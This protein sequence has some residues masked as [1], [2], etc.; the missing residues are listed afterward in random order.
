MT[1]IDFE[2]RVERPKQR[3]DTDEGRPECRGRRARYAQRQEASGARGDMGHE[4][5][6]GHD[7]RDMVARGGSATE[8]RPDM[9]QTPSGATNKVP[10]QVSRQDGGESSD[11]RPD[12]CW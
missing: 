4:R 3:G 5:D 7:T 9:S 6:G 2:V 8:W 1:T 11:G 10:V 12:P